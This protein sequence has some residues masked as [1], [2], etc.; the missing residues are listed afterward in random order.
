MSDAGVSNAENNTPVLIVGAG[1]VGLALA[2]ELGWRGVRC[3]V[4]EQGDGKV[5][6]PKVMGIGMRTMEYCRHW[7]VAE[8]VRDKGYPKDHPRDE[9]YCTAI[10]GH[11][12]AHQPYPPLGETEPPP[13]VAETYQICPQTVFDPILLRRVKTFPCVTIRNFLR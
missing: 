6:H 7:G 13:G 5:E 11:L 3:L 9:Y 8:E 1:P 10:T 12:L 4:A 2:L